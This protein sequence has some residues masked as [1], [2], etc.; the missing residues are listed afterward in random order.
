MRCNVTKNQ[1]LQILFKYGKRYKYEILYALC[2]RKDL[3]NETK[4]KKIGLPKPEFHLVE[5]CVVTSRK[6]VLWERP[7][8]SGRPSELGKRPSELG[9]RS[10]TIQNSFIL[11]VYWVS[12]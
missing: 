3:S 7:N 11:A 12:H 5:V 6:K 4:R 9:K 8:L 2:T 10:S 1:H